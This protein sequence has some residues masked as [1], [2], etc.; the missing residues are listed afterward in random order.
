L[1]P[2]PQKRRGSVNGISTRK[3]VSRGPGHWHRLRRL[4]EARRTVRPK[5][6][7]LSR[8]WDDAEPGPAPAGGD[9]PG[10]GN[11]ANLSR[12]R[13]GDATEMGAVPW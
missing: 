8:P 10:R 4:S 11:P 6:R 2:G 5:M 12:D 3:A 7:T 1:Q 13:S 9:R